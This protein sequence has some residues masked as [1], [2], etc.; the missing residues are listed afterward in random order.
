MSEKRNDKQHGQDRVGL[1]QY[2][3]KQCIVRQNKRQMHGSKQDDRIAR[4]RHKHRQADHRRS[5]KFAV[6]QGELES[7]TADHRGIVGHIRLPAG[8]RKSA[9]HRRSTGLKD[10]CLREP[11]AVAI[12]FKESGNSQPFGMIAAKAG[13][14]SVDFF[15]PVGKPRGSQLVGRKPAAKICKGRSDRRPLRFLRRRSLAPSSLYS[16]LV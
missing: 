2:R 10:R 5:P 16:G 1:P 7:Q 12:A 3:V 15:E 8:Q 11:D 13:V 6:G 14:P 4:G 9:D